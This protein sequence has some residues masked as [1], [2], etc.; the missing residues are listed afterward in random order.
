MKI[1]RLLVPALATCLAFSTVG[2]VITTDDATLTIVNDSD[3]TINEIYLTDVGSST[4]GVNLLRGD[5]LFPDEEFTL[6]VS[7]DYYDALIID[8]TGVRCEVR[9]LDLCLNDSEWFFRNNTCT[10]FNAAAQSKA[11]ADAAKATSAATH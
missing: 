6:G 10:V 5:V 1:H 3:Y 9:D 4:W 2:C 8:D 7:C 11:Q